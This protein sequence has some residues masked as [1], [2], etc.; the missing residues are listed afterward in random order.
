MTAI[1]VL[2]ATSCVPAGTRIFPSVP[3]STASTSLVALSVSISAMTSPDFTL[4]PSFLTHL[5]RLPFSMVGDSAGIN[6]SVG[7]G[8][9]R[10]TRHVGPKLR[11]I[12]LRRVAGEIGGLVDDGA[13][14]AVDLLQV[15]LAHAFLVHK[16]RP[17][18]LDRIVFGTDL[19]HFLA[20]AI[21]RGIRHGMAAVA[22]G[23]HL[24]NVRPLA[25]AGM[26]YRLLA[27]ELHRTYVHAIHLL[28]G[29]AEGK[30]ALGKIGLRRRT[31]DRRAHGVRV[32]LVH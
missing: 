23:L 17:H 18:L 9:L 6:T 1:G 26:R 8:L 7:T 12:G 24:E 4:S 22:V 31:L 10:S 27:G 5:A 2:T 25:T 15:C 21:L 20:R 3:S 29:N 19:V 16:P 13:D 14:L 32:V 28:A 30:P 11:G